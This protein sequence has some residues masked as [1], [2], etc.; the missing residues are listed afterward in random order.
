MIQSTI[1]ETGEQVYMSMGKV[2]TTHCGS[3]Y[4]NDHLIAIYIIILQDFMKWKA[5]FPIFIKKMLC[6]SIE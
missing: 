2:Y 4:N 3:I 1:G 5:L 6:T